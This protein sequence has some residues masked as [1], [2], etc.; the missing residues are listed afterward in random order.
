MNLF[1]FLVLTFLTSSII[2]GCSTYSTSNGFQSSGSAPPVQNRT[3]SPSVTRANNEPAIPYR[4]D[5]K[6]YYPVANASG[7]SRKGIASWYGPKF[8]G[9]KT[10]SGEIY[11]MHSLTAAHKTLPFNTRV[12]VINKLNNRSVIVRIN[13]R[14]PFV[15]RRIIDLSY[16]AGVKLGMVKN[17]T[18]P[19]S[20]RAL[21]PASNSLKTQ[22]P[23]QTSF[24]KTYTVQVGVFKNLENAQ[25]MAKRLGD[26]QVLNFDQSSL[27]LYRVV[28]TAYNTF[29]RAQRRMDT[30]RRLGHQGAFVIAMP[31][32]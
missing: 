22:K 25:L 5:G 18:V 16:G 14:G 12:R 30:L 11:N 3:S 20:L 29:D 6:T 26:G 7:Y 21:E 23:A 28:T 19:V 27:P 32:P 13:D 17:G 10:S 9:K 31:T 15:G 8:H 4:V 24:Q 1:T 2:G